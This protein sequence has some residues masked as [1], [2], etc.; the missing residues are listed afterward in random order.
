[1]TDYAINAYHEAEFARKIREFWKAKGKD[2]QTRIEEHIWSG[3]V[4]L[5]NGS[6]IHRRVITIGVRSNMINGSPR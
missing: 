2:V 4:K 3:D 6:I 5:A 1:M